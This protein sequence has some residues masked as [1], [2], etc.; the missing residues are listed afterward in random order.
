MVEA[1]LATAAIAIALAVVLRMLLGAR[2]EAPI[3]PHTETPAAGPPPPLAKNPPRGPK[4]PGSGTR[5]PRKP[6]PQLGSGAAALP[7]PPARRGRTRAVGRR[8]P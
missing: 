2:R 4:P 6:R 3:A 7:I 8:L 1:L 5:D